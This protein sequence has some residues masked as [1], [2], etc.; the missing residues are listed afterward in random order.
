M[1]GRGSDVRTVIQ[2]F[3]SSVLRG[4]PGPGPART[5]RGRREHGSRPFRLGSRPSFAAE[6]EM[7]RWLPHRACAWWEKQPRPGLG[8]PQ[9]GPRREDLGGRYYL[10]VGLVRR[11]YPS[12]FK[13]RAQIIVVKGGLPEWQL[14]HSDA[15]RSGPSAARSAHP[16]RPPVV[17]E[18]V[19]A[20][21]DRSALDAARTPDSVPATHGPAPA[22]E[23]LA[24]RRL[25]PPPH[26]ARVDALAHIRSASHSLVVRPRRSPACGGSR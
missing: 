19:V 7:R 9:A 11:P 18:Q 21:A 5:P 20:V 3:Y 25:S 12:R 6:A 17:D 2:T 4:P 26:V 24:S 10:E 16:R 22:R 23:L 8:V 1:R 15:Q 13:D 14:E